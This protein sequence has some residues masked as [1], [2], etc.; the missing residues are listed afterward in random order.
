ME[1]S[2]RKKF[3]QHSLLLA[4]CWVIYTCSLIGK[5]NY[6]AN[7][8]QVEAFFNVSHA[9]AGMVSTFYFFAYGA[10]QIINGLFCKKYNLKY[11][12]F[13][14][15][16]V[17]GGA[18]I[19]IGITKNFDLIKYLWLLNGASLSVLWPGLIRLLSENLNREEMSRASIV[20]GT[21]TATGTFIIYGLSAVFAELGI[22][23]FAF[24]TA[25]ICLPLSGVLWI[26][27]YGKL[28]KKNETQAEE[29]PVSIP[30]KSDPQSTVASKGWLV[31]TVVLLAFFAVA[32]N[33]IKD[34]LTTWVPSIL[35]E[36][37][38]LPASVSIF[39]TLALPVVGIFGGMLTVT[40]NKY[41]PDFVCVVTLLFAAIAVLT[42]AIIG[43][44][45]T[46]LV[47]V[48]LIGFAVVKCL[49]SCANGAVTSL[50]PLKMKGKVNSGLI[51]GV[52][53]GCCYV[54]STISSYGF[55][56]V[57][58]TWGWSMVFKLILGVAIAVVVIG[59]VYVLVRTLSA[60]R[61]TQK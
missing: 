20:M 55:G 49:A 54:G 16:F 11:V 26:L 18:N 12:I 3:S 8:T 53:N 45:N 33:L 44:L 57:A 23:K 48:T 29:Q 1:Q 41:V 50:F 52:L 10:G 7:I 39:L 47:A 32:I 30:S 46:H 38:G 2:K 43:L 14:C 4:L 17:A 21:T 60:K 24:Y 56:F 13:T 37:Y 5:M 31:A 6:G 9:D 36:R 59:V 25:G 40:I 51:A 34:G 58:D 22:F 19:A 61:S 27:S 35:N 15:L 42:G 28:T